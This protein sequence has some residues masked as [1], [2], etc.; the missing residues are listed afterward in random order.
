MERVSFPMAVKR[1]QREAKMGNPS[2][3]TEEKNAWR[4][5]SLPTWV[6]RFITH[7]SILHAQKKQILK[8]YMMLLPRQKLLW[9]D[10]TKYSRLADICGCL[11]R[12]C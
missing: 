11:C 6:M 1:K 7:P 2:R 8:R 12:C 4:L 9:A 5:N 10:Q 3:K